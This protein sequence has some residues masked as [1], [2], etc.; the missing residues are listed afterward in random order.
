MKYTRVFCD[1]CGKEQRILKTVSAKKCKFCAN[2]MQIK[3]YK[4]KL[5]EQKRM[6]TVFD[7]KGKLWDLCTMA[8]YLV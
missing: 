7:A 2:T 5:S 8:Y 1:H 4:V 6:F 3:K